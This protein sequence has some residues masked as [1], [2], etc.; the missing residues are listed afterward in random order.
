VFGY[1][2]VSTPDQE[3]RL[4]VDALHAAGV[5]PEDVFFDQGS[6]ATASRPG[7][8]ALLAELRPGDT[9]VAWRLDRL[10]RSVLNLADLLDKL[11]SQDV[12]VR[13]LTDGVD[14]STSMGRML[15]GLLASLAEFERE[16][17]KDRVNAGMAA[18]RRAGIHL[19][20][21]PSLNRAQTEE[22]RRMMAE[23]KPARQVAALLKTSERSLFRAFHRY[24]SSAAP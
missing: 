2:R 15:F 4:Q 22:A 21:P 1:A 7:L 10:G 12:T 5:A 23:G 17:I 6:G 18:A 9:V 20:R 8:D 24:P 16:T 14:T 11:R 3:L 13:S 19:G